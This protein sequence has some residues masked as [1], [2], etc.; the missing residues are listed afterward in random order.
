MHAYIHLRTIC[1][2]NYRPVKVEQKP[3]E[4]E[5]LRRTSVG[6]LSGRSHGADLC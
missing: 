2:V 6:S 4:R 5:G 1:G 3:V